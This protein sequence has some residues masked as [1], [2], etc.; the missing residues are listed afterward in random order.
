MNL[1]INFVWIGCGELGLLEKFMIYSWRACGCQVNLFTHYPSVDKKHDN[2]SLGLPLDICAIHDLPTIMVED[3]D[4]PLG[5]KTRDVLAAW[6]T[7]VMPAWKDGGRVQTFNMVDL[8]KSYIGMHRVG[9]VFDMKVGPSP[10]IK[11]YVEAKVFENNFVSYNR[12]NAAENQCMGSMMAILEGNARWKYGLGFEDGLFTSGPQHGGLNPGSMSLSVGSEW[13]PVATDAHK[14]ALG[15]KGL[16]TTGSMKGL[17]GEWYDIGRD[18]KN[19]HI[20]EGILGATFEG[21]DGEYYGP[22]R[23]FKNEWDQTNKSSNPN[24]T[25][26]Q[27]RKLECERALKYLVPEAENHEMLSK[28][29]QLLLTPAMSNF[30]GFKRF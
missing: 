25:T 30:M 3:N 19:R 2:T 6:Y 10:H 1:T 12:C 28:L 11:K 23:I 13:F 9:V 21:I 24:P 14:K 15:K 22:I 5:K 4:K 27:Q 20:K 16:F 18:G 7:G 29:Q 26:D 8:S 17:R